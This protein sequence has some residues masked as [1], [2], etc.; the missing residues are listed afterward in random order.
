MKAT[1]VA[2]LVLGLA[3]CGARPMPVATEADAARAGTTVAELDHGR[4]L[5]LGHCGSCHQPPSPT[6]RVAAEWP[7]EVDEM[8]ER[9]GL[10]PE[11]AARVT[12]YLTTFAKDQVASQR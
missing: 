10:S 8:A 4:K 6:E 11:Q 5:L 1:C 7:R 12:R 9:S 2:A 3:G